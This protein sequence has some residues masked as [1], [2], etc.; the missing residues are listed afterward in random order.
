MQ[1]QEDFVLLYQ[2][3]LAQVWGRRERYDEPAS[4]DYFAEAERRISERP[5]EGS[6]TWPALPVRRTA[7]RLAIDGGHDLE[8]PPASAGG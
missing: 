2:D 1:E 3:S 5:Q 4:A 7:G 6:V 8:Q